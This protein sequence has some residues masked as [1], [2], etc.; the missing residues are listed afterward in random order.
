LKKYGIIILIFIIL[1]ST[2]LNF[3]Q[4][5]EIRRAE[6]QLTIVNDRVLDNIE[7]YTRWSIRF[8][9]EIQ[10]LRETG[11]TDDFI[12]QTTFGHLQNS[13]DDL[14]E[15][16]AYFV[17]L[18]NENMETEGVCTETLESLR[19]IRSVV[20]H[21]LHEK[22][23]MNQYEFTM[24]DYVFLQD[25]EDVLQ[26][27]LTNIYHIGEANE[28]Q[29]VI[30]IPS[31]QRE[32]LQQISMNLTELGSRYRHSSLLENTEDILS[33]EEANSRLMELARIW[34]EEEALEEVEIGGVYYRNGISHYS[35]ET[36]ELL[37]W[38]D[39]K[40]GTLRYLEYVPEEV[41]ASGGQIPR[42][43]ALEIAK[44]FYG[45]HHG[46]TFD[47]LIRE[48]FTYKQEINGE[49]VHAFRFTP[50]GNNLRLSS[51]AFEINIG[52]S[53]GDVVRF[54][55]RFYDT[56]IPMDAKAT[57]A[58]LEV[59]N[60]EDEELPMSADAIEELHKEEF[61]NLEYQ[62]R[63]VIRNYYTEFRPRVVKV[64]FQEIEGQRAA[65]YFDEFTGRELER[66]YYPYE[67][68]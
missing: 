39:A 5:G 13:L 35:L 48:A 7:Q 22:F 12:S 26:R 54:R 27:F 6:S 46:H 41:E 8:I 66:N 61:P 67:P 44:D 4:F 24:N 56:S 50:L 47:E 59:T 43:E 58:M 15:Y 42:Q 37:L 38:L 14:V 29:L 21:N 45:E 11:N 16:Y 3:Y 34:L 49:T 62:G 2:G 28:N 60:G 53:T 1:V 51:D 17:D 23:D 31:E 32:N 57:L 52:A 18:R 9:D 64:F 36:D 55:N 63:A 10:A 25:M 19:S 20:N 33:E 40:D 65:L 68:F 30:D